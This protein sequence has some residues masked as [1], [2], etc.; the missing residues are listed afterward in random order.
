[1]TLFIESSRKC[2][3]IHNDMKR[4]F[5]EIRWEGMSKRDYKGA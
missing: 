3:T 5:L 4:A 2:K 1:M